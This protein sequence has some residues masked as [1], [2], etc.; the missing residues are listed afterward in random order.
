MTE[1]EH[2]IVRWLGRPTSGRY[3]YRLGK[4]IWSWQCDLH[5]ITVAAFHTFP[6]HG[7]ALENALIHAKNCTERNAR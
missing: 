2:H 3:V 4:G 7:E 6:T 5:D 1:R